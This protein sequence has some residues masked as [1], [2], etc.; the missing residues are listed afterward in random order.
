MPLQSDALS[1]AMPGVPP[2]G[3]AGAHASATS[4]ASLGAPSSAFQALSSGLPTR[5]RVIGKGERR[6]GDLALE[7]EL[8]QAADQQGLALARMWTARPALVVPRSYAAAEGFERACLVASQ[9]GRAVWV[10]G[11]GGGLVPQGRGILN[12]SLAWRTLVAPGEVMESVYHLMADR[13]ALALATLGV[14]ATPA[15]V[16]GSFCDGR[17]NLAVGARKLVGTAQQWRRSERGGH[18][19][20]AHAVILV[21]SDLAAE[22]AVANAFEAALGQ[23]RAYRIEALTTVREQLAAAA[24]PEGVDPGVALQAAL[25]AALETATP[26]QLD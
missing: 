22:L 19:V 25:C 9:A 5:F 4:G 6:R 8:L 26:A 16:D 1:R 10:R 12:L 18:L 13:L 2:G 15:A 20:L 17:F 14:H 24:L 21:D 23:G 7:A 11:S 3:P